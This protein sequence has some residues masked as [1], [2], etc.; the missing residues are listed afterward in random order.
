MEIS[1]LASKINVIKSDTNMTESIQKKISEISINGLPKLVRLWQILIKSFE[2]LK[3]AP[4]EEQACS[5]LGAYFNS[6]K[7]LIKICHNLTSFGN[8]FIEISEI[9]FWIDSVILVSDLIT[10]I[11]DAK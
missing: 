9:F 3:Y 10:L 11:F 7:L 5:S 1:H 6:S 2:E 4:N 8:P